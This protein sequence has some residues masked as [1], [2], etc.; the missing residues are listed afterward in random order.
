VNQATNFVY[1]VQVLTELLCYTHALAADKMQ[2]QP[3]N[4]K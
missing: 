3:L 1:C 2:N 4:G